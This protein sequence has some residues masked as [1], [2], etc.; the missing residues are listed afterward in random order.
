[1]GNNLYTNRQL[2]NNAIC[3]LLT[4]GLYQR[5][6]EEW[7]PL[8]DVQQ[9]WIALQTLIQEAFQRHLNTT[10][11]TAGHHRYA[12]AQPFQQNA[13]GALAKNNDNDKS[14]AA[15]VATR[16]AALTYQSQLTQTTAANTIQHQDQQMVQ[17]EAV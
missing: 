16:V 4:T 5:A 10:A 9:M 7:D 17:I 15:T 8:T 3:L 13:F 2:I 11:P 14:I 6:F 12:P 1:M